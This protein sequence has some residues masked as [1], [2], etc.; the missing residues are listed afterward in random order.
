MPREIQILL[1]SSSGLKQAGSEMVNCSEELSRD[2][3]VTDM[4]GVE[5]AK[6]TE[7]TKTAGGQCVQL[8]EILNILSIRPPNLCFL[9]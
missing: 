2:I 1:E 3:E 4:D 7:F 6:S 5:F 9:L 8:G